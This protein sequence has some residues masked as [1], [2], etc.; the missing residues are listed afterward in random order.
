[1]NPYRIT[2]GFLISLAGFATGLAGVTASGA[3]FS[4]TNSQ[5]VA[6]NDSANDLTESSVY[7]SAIQVTGLSGLILTNL[8]IT[9]P[10]FSHSFPSDVSVLLVNPQGQSAVVMSESGGQDRSPVTGISL[11]FDDNAGS[12]LPE[13]FPLTTGTY[14]PTDGYLG[15]GYT[16]LPYDFPA[17]ALAGNSNSPASFSLFNGVDP[18]GVWNLFVLCD[19]SGTDS[20][21]LS[22]GWS[23][24]LEVGVPLQAAVSRTNV[25]ISWPAAASNSVLQGTTTLS[26]SSVWSNITTIPKASAG[27]FFVTNEISS[28]SAFYRLMSD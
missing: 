15:L 1:M 18:S 19:S 21:A 27:R 17:P 5:F 9:F 7:P 8:T 2:I 20:G 11:T 26:P 14:Q 25:V 6:I 3:S 13:Y 12:P 4:F 24:T 10:S 23:M 28:A 22:N 16:N